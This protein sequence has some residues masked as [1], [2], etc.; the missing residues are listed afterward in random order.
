MARVTAIGGL[1]SARLARAS[2]ITSPLESPSR[3]ASTSRVT[4]A[5]RSLGCLASM[6]ATAASS[7]SGVPGRRLGSGAGASLTCLE[8]TSNTRLPTN[9]GA[10][11][12]IS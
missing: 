9:G 7:H 12:S 6:R 11:V 8:S 4:V 2:S 5:K 10:P 1:V 3:S